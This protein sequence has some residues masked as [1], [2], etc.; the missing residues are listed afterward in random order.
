LEKIISK[1][2]KTLTITAF[3]QVT[4]ADAC[5]Q[6]YTEKEMSFSFKPTKPETYKIRFW[7]GENSQGVDEYTEIEIVIE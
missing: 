4:E 2:G 3:S 6:V 5:T 1:D 7:K